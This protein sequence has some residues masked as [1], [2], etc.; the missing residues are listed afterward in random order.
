MNRYIQRT[1]RL[2]A[3]A[4][5]LAGFEVKVRET[6]LWVA[7]D[8]NLESEARDLV[9]AARRQVE[10]YIRMH[11]EFVTAMTPLEADPL[12]PPVVLEMLKASRRVGVGPMAAVAGTI[13][14]H[15]GRGLLALSTRV[16]VENGGDV[17]LGLQRDVTLRIFAG[18][19]PLSDKL[20]IRLPTGLMPAGVCSSS[21]TVGHSYSS[22]R[23][24]AV[25]VVSPSTAL[26]DAA[27]TALGNRIKEAKDL[28][29][30]AQWAAG[31]EGIT[32]AVMIIGKA[33][34]AWGD[35]ELVEL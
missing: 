31:V 20:G 30:A 24:D 4:R 16:I 33:V 13:A 10:S 5:D 2:S 15:V 11:P 29:P 22:G 6:D 18:R 17:F 3:G 35:L 28:E 1:Y 25:C 7:A 8:R 21:G 32:G 26:A 14:E 23:S 12:A 34:A 27:A 9:L 19:S